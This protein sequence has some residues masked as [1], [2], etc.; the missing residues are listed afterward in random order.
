LRFC[1]EAHE[2]VV[3]QSSRGELGSLASQCLD[4]WAGVDILV[5]NAGVTYFGATHTMP[6]EEWDRLLAVNLRSH[7]ELTRFLLPSML[8]RPEAH[9]LNVCSILGRNGMPRVAAYCATKF[10]MVGFS[11]ALRAE[12]GRAGL[13]VTALCPGFVD[14]GLFAAARPEHDNGQPK[15]PPK[16]LCTSPERVARCAVRAIQRNERM[17][18]VDPL[19]GWVHAA[20]RWLP[21]PFDWALS[22]GRRRRVSEK[23]GQ[24]DELSPDRDTALRKKLGLRPKGE[25]GRSAA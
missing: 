15:T 12:Y 22:L 13:G 24:L 4:R 23:A 17:V 11:E 7:V 21:G 6:L 1:P 20:K 18:V 25:Q 3:D 2:C 8:A 5:N 9:L 10:G 16:W 19:G 14:T